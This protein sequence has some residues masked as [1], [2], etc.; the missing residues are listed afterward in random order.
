MTKLPKTKAR[1]IGVSNHTIEQVG[2]SLAL[3]TSA[4]LYRSML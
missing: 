2:N 1:T 3:M 4:N